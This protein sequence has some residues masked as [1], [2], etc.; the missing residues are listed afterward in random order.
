MSN[1]T[2]L[3]EAN[4]LIHG[5]RQQAYGH[6]ANDYTC[7][8]RIWAAV[9]KHWL[10]TKHPDLLREPIPDIPPEIGCLMMV[11]VK[12]TRAA[13]NPGKR[14]SWVDMAGYAGCGAM[15]VERAEDKA[16]DANTLR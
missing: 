11:G 7:N 5:D 2:V 8:G 16:D 1:E 6:P 12:M 3:E 10:N 13:V 14:D 15:C 9:L 4:R